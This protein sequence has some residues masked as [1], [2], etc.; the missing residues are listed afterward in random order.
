MCLFYLYVFCVVRVSLI[1][2]IMI[3]THFKYKITKT[4]QTDTYLFPHHTYIP[5]N[6]IVQ[7]H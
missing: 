5:I 1:L 2:L 4:Q 3:L 6:S 7:D